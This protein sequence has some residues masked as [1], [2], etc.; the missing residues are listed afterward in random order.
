MIVKLKEN[1][2]I[3]M[4]EK[5]DRYYRDGG[6]G[7]RESH[8]LHSVKEELRSQGWDVIKKRM[9]RDG[10]MVDEHQQYIR[11]REHKFAIWW[12]SY[13]L[14][15]AAEDFNKA[16][17]VELTVERY[18][19]RTTKRGKEVPINF[20]ECGGCGAY[21]YA[22]FAGD[23]RDDANRFK[24]IPNGGVVLNDAGED[25]ELAEGRKA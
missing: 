6:F 19:T 10:H 25:A 22:G 18:G 21:H 20:V 11:D 13:Q 9:W 3:V 16:G 12:G 8:F 1:V 4:K 5:D 24:D 23:C 7:S 14:R 2:C 17:F 15:D